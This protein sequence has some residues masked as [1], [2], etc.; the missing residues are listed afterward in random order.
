MGPG[1]KLLVADF[2]DEPDHISTLVPFMDMAGMMIY[3]GGRERDRAA[4]TR[5]FERT[6]FRFGRLVPLPGCQAIFEGIAV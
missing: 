5:L 1:Q 3:G 6:G 2:L 4:M